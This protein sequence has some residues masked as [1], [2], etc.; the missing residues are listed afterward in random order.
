MLPPT[1]I[2][3]PTSAMTRPKP[4][5]RA[6]IMAKRASRTTTRVAWSG[7]APSPRAASRTRGL[8]SETAATLKAATMGA[9]RRAPGGAPPGAPPP[10][11]RPRD[12]Q[13]EP[14]DAPQLRAAGEDEAQPLPQTA[15]D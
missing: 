7:L 5:M 2:T 9:A 11:G 10:A 15:A 8:T 3:A 12:L 1:I 14:D 6:A 4:A 13:G